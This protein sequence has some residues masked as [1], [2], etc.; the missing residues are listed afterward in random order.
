MANIRRVSQVFFIVLFFFLLIR[1][2]YSGSDEIS[3]PVKIFLD[4][5]PLFAGLL[6][7]SSFTVKPILL[8]SLITVA[9][10]LVLGRFFCGWVCPFGIL[11]NAAGEVA[12]RPKKLEHGLYRKSQTWKYVIL[13]IVAFSG[14]FSMSI[15]GVVDPVSLTVRS[16]SIGI[17]PALE[18]LVR[19]VFD[20]IYAHAPGWASGPSETVY[21]FLREHVLAFNQ[22]HF[23]QGALLGTLFLGLLALNLV[24]P[25]FWCRF[26][27][28]LGALLA[29]LSKASILRLR[30]KENCDAC[31]NCVRACP[32]G[33]SPALGDGWRKA[34]C[35]FCWNCV[36]A[37]PIEALTISFGRPRG[38]EVRTDMTRRSFLWSAGAGLLAIP[39]LRISPSEKRPHP[40]LIRPPGALPEADF[41][42]RCVKCSECMKVCLTNGLQPTLLEAGLE[43]TWSPMLVPTVGYCEY[44]CTLCGQVCPTGAIRELS[45][46]EKRKT[47]IGLA[48]IDKN[49]CL[50]YAFAVNC[51]VCEEHC[52]TPDKAIVFEET[53]A[54]DPYGNSVTLKRPVVIPELCIGCGICEYKCPVLDEPAIYVTNINESRSPQRS[55]LI[56]PKK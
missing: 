29:V 14:F 13:V 27:C 49:R 23:F 56:A 4:L 44:S 18:S 19:T 54:I 28:P 53:E 48:F 2:Q 16:L 37:C 8:L 10:S 45:V 26:V 35:I 47:V 31:G 39:L 12:R 22:P 3:Y 15:L 41:L 6:L 1:T 25:R 5:D 21:G 55:L 51:I 20:G 38:E 50:P 17:G 43:G 32:T 36:E 46:E 33:A 40:R 11:H 7:L 34:D 52:P 24:R 30:L 9:V 42:E